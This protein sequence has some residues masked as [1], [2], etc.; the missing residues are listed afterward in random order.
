MFS[1]RS[2]ERVRAFYLFIYDLFN[3]AVSSSKCETLD[4]TL[5][6][7]FNSK[8]SL[9]FVHY[10]LVRIAV[11]SQIYTKHINTAWA[12]RTVVEC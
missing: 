9:K 11:C 2:A 8:I 1:I 7:H 12:E 4:G 3:D 6:N 5:I 10:V